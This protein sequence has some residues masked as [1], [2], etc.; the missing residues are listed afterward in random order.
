MRANFKH[1]Q[2]KSSF[3]WTQIKENN[4]IFNVLL[5]PEYTQK[6]GIL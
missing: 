6:K 3:W 1:L 5:F 2:T 4:S